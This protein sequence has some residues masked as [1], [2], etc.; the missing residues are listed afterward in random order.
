MGLKVKGGYTVVC[1]K[2]GRRV[3]PEVE[4]G[5]LVVAEE[6]REVSIPG[7]LHVCPECGYVVNFRNRQGLSFG[8]TS[9]R[10]SR[11]R[12]PSRASKGAKEKTSRE[13]HP[14][15]KMLISRLKGLVQ[16]DYVVSRYGHVLCRVKGRN[17]RTLHA[18][19]FFESFR[20]AKHTPAT[21]EDILKTLDR[22]LSRQY[23]SWFDDEFK[24]TL[25]LLIGRGT[26]GV[27]FRIKYRY[28][29]L[30]H[31]VEKTWLAKTGLRF[32]RYMVNVLANL[33]I[34]RIEAF[35]KAL[36]AR[37]I[38]S[39]WGRIKDLIED[40]KLMYQAISLETLPETL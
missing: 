29:P 35:K 9:S 12:K 27:R 31:V 18:F 7:M 5:E 17:G 28:K 26:R 19:G 23:P 22:R 4:D 11:I 20:K 32:Y 33:I 24:Y 39:P 30:A 14:A 10:R 16:V 6:G 15:I 34:K 1:P 8:N 40:L 25:F 3:K 38:S 37:G 13:T 2:C 21:V 36:E